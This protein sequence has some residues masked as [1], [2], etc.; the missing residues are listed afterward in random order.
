MKK[1]RIREASTEMEHLNVHFAGAPHPEAP[2]L[3]LIL[4]NINTNTKSIRNKRML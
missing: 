2:S 3:E 4:L 1:I